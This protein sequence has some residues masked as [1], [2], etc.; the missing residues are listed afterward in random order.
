[1]KNVIRRAAYGA[2]AI[3]QIF[4][5][6]LGMIFAL[7]FFGYSNYPLI[8]KIIFGILTVIIFMIYYIAGGE[9]N[10]EVENE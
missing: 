10:S 2:F 1:M 7:W 4:S 8:V 9:D 6:M 5:N 3:V